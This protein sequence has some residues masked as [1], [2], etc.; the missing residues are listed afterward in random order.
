MKL[1][2]IV[3]RA[4]DIFVTEEELILICNALNEVCNGLDVEEF[5]TRMGT[6]LENVRRLFG[7]LSK[8]TDMVQSEG[9]TRPT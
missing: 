5:D 8:V 9:S 2:Q 6:S 1:N 7:E 3:D 4:A